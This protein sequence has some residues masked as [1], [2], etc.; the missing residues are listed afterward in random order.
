M[1]NNLKEHT[2]MK[3][4]IKPIMEETEVAS[5]NMIAVSNGQKLGFGSGTKN[6]GLAPGRR[7]NSDWDP[8]WD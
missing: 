4:Y 3:A 7:R 1:N 6:S 5:Q 8:D 2:T